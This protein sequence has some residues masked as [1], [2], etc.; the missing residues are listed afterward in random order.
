MFNV[1]VFV[2]LNELDIILIIF[3]ISIGKLIFKMVFLNFEARKVLNKLY[4]VFL[5]NLHYKMNNLLYNFR[6]TGVR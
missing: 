4:L 6:A 3:F 5:S 2:F 1:I